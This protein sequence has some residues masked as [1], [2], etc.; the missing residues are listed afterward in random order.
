ASL[1]VVVSSALRDVVVTEGAAPD[2]VLV[3]P[4]GVDV[5]E[6][7]PYRADTP[8]EWR[9]RKGLPDQ[10]TVGFIGTFELWHGVH[11]LPGLVEAVPGA[12]WLIIGDGPLFREV[13]DEMTARSVEDRVVLSGLVERTQALELLACCDVCVSPHVP[14]PDGTPFFGS[15]TKLFEYMG[16]RKAIVASDLGQIGDVLTHEETALLCMPGDV[17]GVATGIRRLLADPAFRDR[18]ANAAFDL[19]ASE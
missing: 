1:V 16:L 9:K 18:L 12:R 19:A 11:L 4:N 3:N 17:P 14:N 15:P 2:R 5:A 7:M 8:G 6:L 10:P 13:R